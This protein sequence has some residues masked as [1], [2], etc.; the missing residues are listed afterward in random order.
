MERRRGRRAGGGAAAAAPPLDAR[1]ALRALPPLIKGY[2]R[3]G[4]KFSRQAVIDPT[5]GTT[6]VLAVLPIEGITA[7]VISSISRPATRRGPLAA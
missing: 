1:A 2:W 3:L 7:R 6:D 5:F 4:A